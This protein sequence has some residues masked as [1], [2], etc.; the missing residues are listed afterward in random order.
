MFWCSCGLCDL[1][2]TILVWELGLRGLSRFLASVGFR[3]GSVLPV[4]AAL[5]REA[6]RGLSDQS[7]QVNQVVGGVLEDEGGIDLGQPRAA[8]PGAS[9]RSVSA[10]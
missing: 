7:W 2:S 8:S 3:A 1:L 10:I 6:L 9:S 5:L 4:H